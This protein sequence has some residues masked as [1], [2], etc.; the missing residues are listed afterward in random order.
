MP[1]PRPAA[2]KRQNYVNRSPR[3][4]GCTCTEPVTGISASDPGPITNQGGRQACV[5]VRVYGMVV[6]GADYS[7]ARATG[8]GTSTSLGRT[9]L[10][11]EMGPFNRCPLG[12]VHFSHDSLTSALSFT[13]PTS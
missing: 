3:G 11:C 8:K 5:V 12:A 10:D 6:V 13:N 2:A 4:R 1:E 7:R 9:V